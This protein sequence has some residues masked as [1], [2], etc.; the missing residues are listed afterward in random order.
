MRAP[1]AGR[2]P[3]PAAR[4]PGAGRR[5]PVAASGQW[6]PRRALAAG[7]WQLA[8]TAHRTALHLR[9]LHPAPCAH[10]A[11]LCRPASCRMG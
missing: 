1:G 8:A 11:A 4:A 9:T 2:R 6:R 7:S 3:P 5:A 10:C